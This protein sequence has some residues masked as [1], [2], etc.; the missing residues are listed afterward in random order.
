MNHNKLIAGLFFAII[1]QTCILISEYANAV[2]PLLTG[3]EIYL[4]TIPVDPRCLFRGNYAQLQYDISNIPQ[5]NLNA[6]QKLRNGEVLYVQLQP[7]NE[8]FYEYSGV[9]LQKPDTGTFIR[10]RIQNVWSRERQL[11]QVKYGI[12]AYFA[13][14]KK[15]QEIERKLRT[16]GI[17]TVMV[18]KNG[19]ASLKDISWAKGSNL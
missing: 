9:S 2:Y 18:A 19:K 11:Y 6:G 14:K 3:K 7:S 1:F 16:G 12:E 13:P 5:K 8:G 10:G 4:K 15:A 17:A